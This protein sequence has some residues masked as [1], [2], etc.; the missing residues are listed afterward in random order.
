M[1]SD[2]K[3]LANAVNPT[4]WEGEKA[5]LKV[6]DTFNLM[7]ILAAYAYASRDEALENSQNPDLILQSYA[8]NP[9]LRKVFSDPA[10]L[11]MFRDNYDSVA[12]RNTIIGIRQGPREAILQQLSSGDVYS[13]N[14]M[15]NA[16]V[17]VQDY[18]EPRIDNT[19]ALKAA[20]KSVNPISSS[21]PASFTATLLAGLADWIGQQA[22]EEFVQTFLMRLQQDLSDQQLNLLFPNTFQYLDQLNLI[23]Y[24]SIIA[25][26][27][28]AFAKDLN[29][30][31]L[32][33]SEYL[34]K[35]GQLD[36]H[37]PLAFSLLLIYRLVDLVQ[38]DLQLPQILA[39]A[40][41]EFSRR[42]FESEKILHD[43][44]VAKP[45]ASTYQAVQ[46]AFREVNT[47]LLITYDSLIHH[48]QRI[49]DELSK[50]DAVKRLQFKAVNQEVLRLQAKLDSFNYA[51]LFR[52]QQNRFLT[53]VNSFLNGELD[54][55]VL[56]AYPS[57]EVYQ[58]TFEN[59]PP[60]GK[61]LRGAGLSMIRQLLRF[62]NGD[63]PII[64]ALKDYFKHLL[65]W[66]DKVNT[67]SK[68]VNSNG[69]NA[70]RQFREELDTNIN[71][72]SRFWTPIASTHEVKAYA[73]LTQLAANVRA[74]QRTSEEQL[75]Y[76]KRVDQLFVDHTWKLRN[77]YSEGINSPYFIK[78]AADTL[79]LRLQNEI[80]KDSLLLNNLRANLRA[81]ETTKD[82]RKLLKSYENASLFTSILQSGTQLMYSLAISETDTSLSWINPQQM[83][84]IL[85]DDVERD[86]FLGLLY[87]RISA[88]TGGF[89]VDTR[90]LAQIA[91]DVV[92]Q[93][94]VLDTVTNKQ[95]GFLRKIEFT[96]NVINSILETPLIKT[97]QGDRLESLVEKFKGQG[98][99]KVPAINRELTELFKHTENKDYR[100]GLEN[101]LKLI[102]LFDIYPKT[103]KRRQR[104]EKRLSTNELNL[105][106]LQMQASR[107]ETPELKVQI[108]ELTKTVDRIE[109]K[110]IKHDSTRYRKF[111]NG[112][113]KYGHFIADVAAAETPSAV[114]AAMSSIALP[115]GSSQNKRLRPFSVE[116]NA[117]FGGTVGYERILD[118]PSGFENEE[119]INSYGLFVPVG[120][121]ISKRL[122][123]KSN[124]SM[125]LFVPIID[126]GALSA[127]RTDANEKNLEALPDLSFANVL[128]PGVH[129][130]L[131]LPR[132]PFFIG[133]G[134]QY[135][136]NVR[137]IDLNGE[138]QT[139]KSLRYMLTFGVDVP[140]LPFYGN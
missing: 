117:Y 59:P 99:A 80:I 16:A 32:N 7:G 55:A 43:T 40:N 21:D 106:S 108:E 90:G 15:F 64:S 97:Y 62:E 118:E 78:Q 130:M 52:D 36:E 87:Q 19:I 112:V 81:L 104:L 107:Q 102:D 8:Y 127:F 83:A 137:E 140:I 135:G 57:F 123:K 84:F 93:L 138:F 98:I 75:D 110:I 133:T 76:L 82:N 136:P 12:V 73:Y 65:A 22:Q 128:A 116:L 89:A 56:Q 100:Y 54:Y 70:V 31:S 35:S 46:E 63:Y 120:V 9:Y 119:E 131:N 92:Q 68:L 14:R 1:A 115:A 134:I 5:S 34:F 85:N 60:S 69:R 95:S 29:T 2:V 74:I 13:K 3:R 41:G 30:L 79:S 6:K 126:L 103:K 121:S 4:E 67:L 132:S 101:V 61:E 86:F 39:Y 88:L 20:S 71:R 105:Q 38:R 58:A 23:N 94:S 53:E 77:E 114:Q 129:L 72:E 50:I 139:L 122:G 25:N 111:R 66:E 48:K 28:L 26:A 24:R 125:S 42:K 91:T 109:N 96:A 47:E 33:I 113:F 44:L 10:I 49:A 45:G 51:G 18:Q 124:F 17:L 27:R 11:N 37:D